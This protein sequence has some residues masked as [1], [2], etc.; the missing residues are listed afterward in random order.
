MDHSGSQYSYSGFSCYRTKF[1]C[2]ISDLCLLH[3]AVS[4]GNCT[5]FFYSSYI[6]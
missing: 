5:L 3:K 6:I 1:K 4:H 2:Y